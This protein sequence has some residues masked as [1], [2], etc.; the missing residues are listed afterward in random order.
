MSDSCG[1]NPERPG[2]V[3]IGTVM[4]PVPVTGFAANFSPRPRI[5]PPPLGKLIAYKAQQVALEEVNGKVAIEVLIY[6]RDG[7]MVAGTGFN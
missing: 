1:P 5:A 6:D 2:E 7:K 3:A 4:D